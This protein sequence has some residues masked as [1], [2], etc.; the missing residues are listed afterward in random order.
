MSASALEALAAAKAAGVKLTLDGDG[1]IL[2]AKAA[3]LRDDLVALLTAAKPDLLRILEWRDAARAALAAD[4]P[5]DCGHMR[6]VTGIRRWIACDDDGREVV[7]VRLIHGAPESR[8]G[9]AIHGLRRFASEG[10]A[11]Q[12]VLLGW[13]KEELY[14][15][16]PLWARIH[17]A[18]AALLIGDARVVAVTEASIVVETPTGSRLMFRRCG[19]EHVA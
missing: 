7:N 16:P 3:E 15:V 5:L 1:I 4:P 19:R 10:C 17:L 18:G 11:D 9:L 14:R 13:T 2:E 6:P 12:A 8:W